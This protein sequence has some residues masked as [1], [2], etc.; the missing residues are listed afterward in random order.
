MLQYEDGTIAAA[1]VCRRELD[2]DVQVAT[3]PTSIHYKIS[4][5]AGGLAVECA[6]QDV[7]RD[8]ILG[9]DA[10]WQSITMQSRSEMRWW[11]DDSRTIW[12]TSPSL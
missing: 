5:E 6:T 3:L 9:D 1:G 2:I 4:H 7:G 10:G 11:F 12:I 8:A